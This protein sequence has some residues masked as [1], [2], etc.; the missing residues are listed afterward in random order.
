M[1]RQVSYDKMCHMKMALVLLSCSTLLGG[2]EAGRQEAA[3]DFG[4]AHVARSMAAAE[5]ICVEAGYEDLDAC[6]TAPR[7]TAAKARLSI[8][9]ARALEQSYRKYCAVDLGAQRCDDMLMSA[10]L[11]A[12]AR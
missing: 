5:A 2:C 7:E 4:A 1:A 6:A 11:S 9:S 3:P 12:Q 8:L 10:Y